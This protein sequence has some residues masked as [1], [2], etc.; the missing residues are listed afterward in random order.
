MAWKKKNRSPPSPQPPP[1]TGEKQQVRKKKMD[2]KKKQIEIRLS[3]RSPLN[4]LT[5][6]SSSFSSSVSSSISCERLSCFSFGSSHS[7][8]AVTKIKP[9]NPT[10][11]GKKMTSSAKPLERTGTKNPLKLV[12]DRPRKQIGQVKK[13]QKNTGNRSDCSDRRVFRKGGSGGGGCEGDASS[14]VNTALIQQLTPEKDEIEKKTSSTLTTTMMTATPPIEASI[15]PEIVGV[16]AASLAPPTCFA[17]GCLISGIPDGRK[18]CK[19]RGIL[20]VGVDDEELVLATSSL[21]KASIEWIS[22]PTRLGGF[23]G[24]SGSATI[25]VVDFTGED[26]VNWLLPLPEHRTPRFEG[27]NQSSASSSW[28]FSPTSTSTTT[29]S[30][31]IRICRTPTSD[32]SISPFSMIIKNAA[33]TVSSNSCDIQFRSPP[34]SDDDDVILTSASSSPSASKNF[35]FD[36]GC[37]ITA[38]NSIDLSLFNTNAATTTTASAA[39]TNSR[40]TDNRHEQEDEDRDLKHDQ[41]GFGSFELLPSDELLR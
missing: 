15:S 9:R 4:G 6:P 8:A 31:G 14:T 22:S 19:P 39:A 28:R 21:A 3:P 27:S 26:S 30:Y 33:N 38:S 34:S 36:F 2:K 29:P 32:S 18:K 25:P 35:N 16:G 41:S 10:T 20:K 5:S 7:T 24:C 37:T 23:D 1:T 11:V 40:A 13:N 12:G 17:A